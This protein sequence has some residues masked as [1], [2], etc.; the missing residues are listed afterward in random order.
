[1]H[2]SSKH[3]W[4]RPFRTMVVLFTIIMAPG[5]L[6]P[7]VLLELCVVVPWAVPSVCLRF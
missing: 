4:A 5:V 2:D 1:M 3:L 7:H 6:V